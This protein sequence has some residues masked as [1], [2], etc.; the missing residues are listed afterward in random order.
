MES[1]DT[2]KEDIGGVK[3]ISTV[4]KN[5]GGLEN[6]ETAQ[7]KTRGL[8]NSKIL[9]KIIGAVHGDSNVRNFS[10]ERTHANNLAVVMFDNIIT[11]ISNVLQRND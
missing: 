2:A 3:N 11:C 10:L 4:N 1:L 9:E 6:T 7:E 8:D 5:T